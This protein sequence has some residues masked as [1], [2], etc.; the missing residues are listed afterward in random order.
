MLGVVVD[1]LADTG[2]Y[3]LVI[4]ASY[5]LTIVFVVAEVAW[6]SRRRRVVASLLTSSAMALG[7]I[8]VGAVYTLVLGAVWS[9]LG[10]HNPFWERQPAVAA[11]VAFVVWDVAGWLYHRLGH[12]TAFGWAS[13]QV[14]HSGSE[15]D[16]TLALRQTWTPFHGLVHQPLVALLGFDLRVIILCSAVSNCWFEAVVM[17]PAAHRQHHGAGAHLVNLGPVFTVWDRLAGSWVPP[18]APAP[19]SYG[20]PVAA[21]RNP[22]VVELAGWRELVRQRRARTATNVAA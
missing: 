16:A 1:E 8:A 12:A 21:S 13:H 19:V 7:A 3:E 22:F 9:V 2:A 6:L 10:W 5:A 15:Y 4:A 17:T 11:V 18:D 14:H 20:P